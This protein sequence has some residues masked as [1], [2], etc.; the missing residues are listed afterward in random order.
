MRRAKFILGKGILNFGSPY[1]GNGAN[2]IPNF[3]ISFTIFSLVY[4]GG[5]SCSSRLLYCANY[6]SLDKSFFF[7]LVPGLEDVLSFNSTLF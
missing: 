2:L 4:E 6:S 1:S 5:D 3:F 7:F